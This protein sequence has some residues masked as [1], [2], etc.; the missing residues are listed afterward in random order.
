MIPIHLITAAAKNRQPATI[1]EFPAPHIA[2]LRPSRAIAQTKGLAILVA[3]SSAIMAAILV[4][5][6]VTVKA[7]PGD[8]FAALVTIL[9]LVFSLG[10]AVARRVHRGPLAGNITFDRRQGMAYKQAR[11]LEPVWQGG[12]RLRDVSAIELV[13]AAQC[14]N[15]VRWELYLVSSARRDLRALL[16]TDSMPDNLRT[17]A[18]ELSRFLNIPLTDRSSAV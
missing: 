8:L 7:K 9:L 1:L 11:R 14:A 17:N 15:Q 2:V 10:L 13:P 4:A 18:R 3:V 6:A 16:A 12:I 5:K